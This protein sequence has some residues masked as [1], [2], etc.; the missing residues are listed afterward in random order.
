[1]IR[2]KSVPVPNTVRRFAGHSAAGLLTLIVIAAAIGAVH[3]FSRPKPVPNDS[4]TQQ[5]IQ[6]P[7]DARPNERSRHLVVIAHNAGDAS[8]TIA[9]ALNHDAQFVEIDTTAIQ[10]QL[11]ARHDIRPRSPADYIA[12][13]TTVNRAWE[14][15]GA[16]GVLLDLKTNGLATTSLIRSLAKRHAASRVLV[17]T[18]DIGSLTQLQATVPHLVRLLSIGSSDE[19]RNFLHRSR[20]TTTGIQGVAIAEQLLNHETISNLL[21]QHLWI[22]A[23]T[24]NTMRRTNELANFGVNGITTDNLTIIETLSNT[25]P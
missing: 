13:S 2:T 22:Q 12:R 10:G 3:V 11:R 24:V 5:Q 18:K 20:T 17:S 8:S 1:M 7:L 19:L 21:A 4:Y 16:S 23:W 9:A 25:E 15:A 6:G 14:Q